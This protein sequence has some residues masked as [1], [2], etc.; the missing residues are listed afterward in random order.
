MY[1]YLGFDF[2][3]PL[4]HEAGRANDEGGGRLREVPLPIPANILLEKL[5]SFIKEILCHDISP[6]KGHKL[7]NGLCASKPQKAY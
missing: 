7:R 3:L 1:R 2:A 6:P 4:R 5:K